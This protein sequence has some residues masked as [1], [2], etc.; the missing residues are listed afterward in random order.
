MTLVGRPLPEN[1]QH[2]HLEAVY[3]LFAARHTGGQPIYSVTVMIGEALW[4]EPYLY[5]R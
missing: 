4:K 2:R 3:C 1:E 5:L